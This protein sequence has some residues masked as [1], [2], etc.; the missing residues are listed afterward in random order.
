MVFHVP[1]YVVEQ[2][3]KPG[4]VPKVV[5]LDRD[6]IHVTYEMWVP[7]REP[8]TW[9]GVDMNA[10]NNTYAY[11]NG[12]TSTVWNEYGNEYNK[13]CSKILNVKR[14]GDTRIMEKQTKKAWKKY[15]NRTRD[16]M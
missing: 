6:Q 14:R 2:L 8:A 16:H 9:A 1:P 10:R 15:Q 5:K 11:P 13:A 7:D 4:V 12:M 3:T